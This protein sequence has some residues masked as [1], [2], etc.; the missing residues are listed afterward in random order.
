MTRWTYIQAALRALEAYTRTGAQSTGIDLGL[1]LGH[2]GVGGNYKITCNPDTLLANVSYT[3]GSGDTVTN[4]YVV[5]GTSVTMTLEI[6]GFTS[7]GSIIPDDNVVFKLAGLGLH[8]TVGGKDVQIPDYII[9]NDLPVTNWDHSYLVDFK[10][11]TS[12]AQ[13]L[14]G[15]GMQ[16]DL[17]PN[18]F[19]A[20]GSVQDP[21]L[22]STG[23]FESGVTWTNIT[24]Y[25][26]NKGSLIPWNAADPTLTYNNGSYPGS[27]YVLWT[28]TTGTTQTTET[29]RTLRQ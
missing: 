1:M 13:T 21:G 7:G 25:D 14:Y 18:A 3:D 28:T 29:V 27:P 17:P 8:G 6:W 9:T 24:L 11:V 19:P 23:A 15:T 26:A 5:P 2:T 12:I 10:R 22:Y 16:A 20:T 4:V